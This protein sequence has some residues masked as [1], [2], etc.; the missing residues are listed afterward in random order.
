MLRFTHLSKGYAQPDGFLPV[1]NDVSGEVARGESVALLGESGSGKSTLL[2]LVAGLDVPD[3]GTML[4]ND[5]SLTDASAQTWNR[6]RREHISLVFQDFHLIPTLNVDDNLKLQARLAGQLDLDFCNQ[7][8]ERLGLTGLL[9]GLP[10]ELSGGQQ[11]RVAIARSLAH[12]PT[13]VLADEPTGNL[14]EQT[15]QDVMTLLIDCVRAANSSLL[16]V[17]HSPAMAAYLDRRWH[18]KAGELHED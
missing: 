18:L 12:R 7:L 5:I 8:I 11:Q 15:A 17:T 16:M 14:D 1:L 4:L 3:H 10:G 2:H 9:H 6:L 13:L